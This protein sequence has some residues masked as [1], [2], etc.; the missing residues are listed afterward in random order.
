MTR[1]KISLIACAL[2][3]G[4][5]AKADEGMWLPFLLGRNYEDMKAH[6]LNLTEAEIYDINNSS[7]KDA[8][9]SFNGYCTGEVVSDQGLI[10][11]N[12]HCGYPSIAGVSTEENNYLDNGFWAKNNGEEIA[13]PGLYASFIVRIQ[14][15]SATINGVLTKDMTED[16]RT[17]AIKKMSKTLTE[18]AVVGTEY[19]AFVRDFFAGN[20]FYL[21]VK[22]TFNDVRLVGTP[23]QS[24]GKFGGDTDNWMWPRHTA[25]FS[26]FRI[27]ANSDNKAS[28]YSASNVPFVPKHSLPISIKGVQENDYAMVLGYPGSTD[29]YISSWGVKQMVEKEYPNRIKIRNRK[30]EIMKKYMDVDVKDRLNY[31]SRYA[32]VANY[33]KNFIGMSLQVKQNG[34][35]EKK[36][37]VEAEYRDYLKNVKMSFDVLGSIEK[38]YKTTNA[39]IDL[40]SYQNEFVGRITINRLALAFN[41]WLRTED[42]EAKVKFQE[43]LFGALDNY[44]ATQ[45]PEIELEIVH[46]ILGMYIDD[47]STE[48]MGEITKALAGKGHKGIDKYIKKMKKKSM[49]FNKDVYESFKKDPTAKA[50]QK[51]PLFILMDDMNNAYKAAVGTEEMK[52][53]KDALKKANR[54]FVSGLRDMQS[55][56]MFYPNANSTLR[57]SYGNVL[58]Y[59]P[60]DGVTYHFTTTLDGIMQKEDP[61]NP[62]F[63]VDPRIKAA[64]EKKDYGQYADKDGR[65][66]VNFLSN[67]DIT[68]GNSGS[69][70][71]NGDGELIG[72]AFDGNWEA[73]S[74]D[75]YFEP[76]IQRTISLDVRYTLWLIDKCFGATNIIAEMNLVK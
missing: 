42:P 9:I 52:I 46:D 33:W 72:T 70:V 8:I 36:E 69:P 13:I 26:M 18:D 34:V 43:K 44:Y 51:D 20:E 27:Y 29:R 30:L 14:D 48:Q 75:I 55:N 15:V 38:Y 24:V 66:V 60:K 1:I 56:K 2:L 37:A 25:D 35:V 45:N 31:S 40:K 63:V 68:G 62:E 7:L 65:L 23:P 4:T 22:E 39:T 16:E 3:F 5:F 6:G 76:N 73:M 59:D 41:R 11:T 32:Q 53:A 17:A 12:H 19:T 10:L 54:F 21:F 61:T 64:W 58:P 67:N 49:F 71:I 47:I 50:I 74:G 28:Q 57:L